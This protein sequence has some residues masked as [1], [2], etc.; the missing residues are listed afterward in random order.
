M[1]N[2]P[3]SLLG[4]VLVLLLL[5]IFLSPD[6]KTVGPVALWPWHVAID[7]VLL[8]LAFVLGL[9]VGVVWG[10]RLGHTSES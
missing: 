8:P 2:V 10:L 6:G 3:A 9:L 7:T 5:G 1:S 4:V